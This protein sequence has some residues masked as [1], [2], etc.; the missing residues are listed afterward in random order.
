M[1]LKNRFM[2]EAQ[3]GTTKAFFP[4]ETHFSPPDKAERKY[5]I[6]ETK[7]KRIRKNLLVKFGK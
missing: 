1:R 4:H 5:F 7:Q 2:H 6:A 3:K